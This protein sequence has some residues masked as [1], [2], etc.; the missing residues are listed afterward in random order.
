MTLIRLSK[1]QAVKYRKLNPDTDLK[2][3]MNQV[4]GFTL[5][6]FDGYFETVT[7]YGEA[8]Q[9]PTNSPV[10]PSTVYI[11]VNKGYPGICKI[12][13]TDNSVEERCKNINAATGVIYPWY[14]VYT[15]KCMNGHL[16]EQEVHKYLEDRGVRVNLKREGFEISSE[17]AKKII[18]ELGE[19]YI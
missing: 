8:L 17:E 3:N 13:Y 9:D 19:K 11:L 6:Y 12:G 4:K 18:E 16:L 10:K 5:E 2:Y 14:Y 7:Y 15:F 1:E